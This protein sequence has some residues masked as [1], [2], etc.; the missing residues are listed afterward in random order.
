MVLAALPS[1]CGSN[2]VPSINVKLFA[3]DSAHDGFTRAQNNTTIECTS[4][5][6]DD[7]VAMSYADL[8]SIY[9]VIQECKSWPQ[10]MKLVHEKELYKQYSPQI[11]HFENRR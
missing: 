9:T 6:I 8:K 5:A 3:G 2:K 4:K 11:K 7:Y 10:D 1:S